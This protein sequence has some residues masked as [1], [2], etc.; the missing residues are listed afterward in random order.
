MTLRPATR[1]RGAGITAPRRVRGR[2]GAAPTR[3]ETG[4]ARRTK[5]P[6]TNIICVL[7]DDPVS[8]YPPSYARHSVPTIEQYHGGQNTLS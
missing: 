4:Q 2:S 7:Y 1:D 5:G 6:M 3:R 8:G